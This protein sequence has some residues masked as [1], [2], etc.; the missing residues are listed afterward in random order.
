MRQR[1]YTITDKDIQL[2][3][4]KVFQKH[5]KLRNHGPKCT[6]AVLL[7][8]LFYAAERLISLTAACAAL[9]QAPSDQAVRDALCWR[10]CPASTNCNAAPIAPWRAT[11]P[12]PCADI[13]NRWTSTWC[14]SPTTDNRCTMPTKSIGANPSRGPA[15]FTPMPPSMSCAKAN[16]SPWV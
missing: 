2:H 10:P 15:I 4:D 12:K 8:L 7:N 11:Y 6:G 16:A 1:Q 14:S 3:A 13:A 5:L 9:V